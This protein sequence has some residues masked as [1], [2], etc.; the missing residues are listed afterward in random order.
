M[1]RDRKFDLLRIIACFMVVLLHVSAPYVIQNTDNPNFYFTIGNFYDSISRICVPIFVMISGAFL[2]DNNKNRDYMLFYKKT[3]NKII[4]P[5]MIWSFLYFLFY[6]MC[7][8]YEDF[9]G[10]EVNYL[11]PLI[12]WING[13]PY[14]HLWYLYMIIGLYLITPFLIMIRDEI[15]DN[16]FLK[17]GYILTFLGFIISITSELF[18]LIKFINYLGYFILGY[19][20]RKKQDVN[21]KKSCMFL[22]YWFITAIGI[23]IATELIVVNGW[24]NKN[25]LYFYENLS[26]L[27]LIG[28]I[29]MF[30]AFASMGEIRLSPLVDRLAEHSFNIYTLHVGILFFVNQIEMKILKVDYNLIWYIPFISI[31]VFILSYGT[32][33]L[34]TKISK[35]RLIYM[36]RERLK[37]FKPIS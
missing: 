32:S 3:Y 28:S 9:M 29:T 37:V 19:S 30:S 33:I 8:M 10:N 2:I 7:L 27:V 34:I 6:L 17:L 23:F 15:G 22:L 35:I 1:R 13:K 12:S 4:I 18:W 16:R 11:V 14:Y 36:F 26:P 5:T 24:L 21:F 31:L 25:P 20:I